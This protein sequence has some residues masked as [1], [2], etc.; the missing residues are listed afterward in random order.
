[1]QLNFDDEFCEKAEE[2]LKEKGVKILTNS[3]AEEIGGEKKVEYVKLKG[4]EKL[5]ADVVILG[6]GA[7]TNTEIGEKAGLKMGDTR[8]IWV[9]DFQR[10]S[11]TDIFAVGDCAEKRFS[12]TGVPTPLLLAS[13]AGREAK[14]AGANLFGLRYKNDGAV[15]AFSTIIGDTA[16]GAAGLVE[17][18][19][20]NAG[21]AYVKGEFT[22]TDKHPGTLPDTKKSYLKLLFTKSGEIIGGEVYG[23]IA[24]GELTNIIATL[25]EKRMRIDELVTLQVGT[26]PWLTGSPIGYLIPN[27]AE[28][29]IG[30][31]S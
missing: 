18:S 22:T 13:I 11:D 2:K 26:Q 4:G 25:I 8:A 30:K 27:A 9:D 31:L 1:L 20:K 6:I 5:D 3:T 24:T 7:R 21:V 12:L 29:A 23:G 17:R 10:T 15:G 14:I 16:F 19:A 28:M